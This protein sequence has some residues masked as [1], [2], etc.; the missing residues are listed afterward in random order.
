MSKCD[1]DKVAKQVY[2]NHTLPWVFSCKSAAHFSNTF[3]EEH[4]WRAASV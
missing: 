2:G 4:L 3:L 1:F